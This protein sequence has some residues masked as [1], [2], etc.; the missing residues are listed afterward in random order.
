MNN[1][2]ISGVTFTWD[3]DT[4]TCTVNG[5]CTGWN[6]SNIYANAS[7]LPS[8]IIP[9]KSYRLL[10][11]TTSS[12][13][14]PLEVYIYRSN[15]DTL[16]TFYTH[17]SDI[18]IP[19]D[20]IGIVFRIRIN[21]GVE[22]NND[23]IILHGLLTNWPVSDFMDSYK[24]REDT[25]YHIA[26][27]LNEYVQDGVLD[28][29]NVKKPGYY[30]INDSWTVLNGASIRYAGLIVE[31]FSSTNGTIFIKQ[32]TT[33]VTNTNTLPYTFCRWVN[34][35]GV[36]SPW[37]RML[38]VG[39]G[40]VHATKTTN[41]ADSC[42]DIDLD[43]IRFV[44]YNNGDKDIPDFPLNRAGWLLN[45]VGAPLNTTLRFQVVL[46]YSYND[47]IKYRVRDID[48]QWGGLGWDKLRFKY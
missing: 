11:E 8:V 40:L 36:W 33:N 26:K 1:K 4:K 31:R 3:T 41:P 12:N 5:T 25:Y 23:K 7:G 38:S 42:D 18:N 27:D 34:T 47:I 15:A 35:G 24:E 28:L 14:L 46:P 2:T 10:M 32:T 16:H 44:S 37:H 39:D 13:T 19:E 22:Y 29:D 20:A 48:N 43:S 17:D 21:T 6:F 45:F 9:G 30:I